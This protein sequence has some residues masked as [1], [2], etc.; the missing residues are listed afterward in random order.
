MLYL[1][2]W[3]LDHCRKATESDVDAIFAIVND[4]YSIELGQEGIAFTR[5]KRFRK[6]KV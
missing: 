5:E 3:F 4:A 6:L 2:C 1:R